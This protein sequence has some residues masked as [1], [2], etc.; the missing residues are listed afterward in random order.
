MPL[1]IRPTVSRSQFLRT[2]LTRRLRLQEAR[3]AREEREAAVVAVVAPAVAEERAVRDLLV[4]AAIA[5][6]ALRVATAP[7]VASADP[8]LRVVTADLK[9]VREEE[10][11][12][13]ADT[14]VL[15]VAPSSLLTPRVMLISDLPAFRV[16][17]VSSVAAVV[18]SVAVKEEKVDSVAVAADSAVALETKLEVAVAVSEVVLDPMTAT[19]PKEVV[20]REL[21]VP[22]L[23]EALVL[24]LSDQA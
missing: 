9:E 24:S 20:V 3:V 15:V 2:R 14:E 13:E 10:V 6:P 7:S 16:K 4:R 8:A 5:D 23:P 12:P 1:K 19:T 18:D 22:A 21:K 17:L 11:A